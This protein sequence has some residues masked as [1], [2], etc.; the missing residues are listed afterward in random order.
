LE[1]FVET[2]LKFRKRSQKYSPNLQ[3]QVKRFTLTYNKKFV[4]QLG[5]DVE[6]RF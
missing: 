1:K 6:D 2:S 3:L 4:G 5:K